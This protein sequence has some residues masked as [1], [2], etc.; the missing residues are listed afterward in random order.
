MSENFIVFENTFIKR[1]G[2]LKEATGLKFTFL[3]DITVL[4]NKNSEIVGFLD[5][6]Y[7]KEYDDLYIEMIE[8]I[9]KFRR[10]GYARATI[11]KIKELYP[12]A[13]IFGQ[14]D[15]TDTRYIWERLGAD[16]DSCEDVE[17]PYDSYEECS[18]PCDNPASLCFGFK[19]K[20]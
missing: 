18:Y 14:A 12:N 1:N 4:K 16:F 13:N 10:Q 9:P 5:Y 15:N 2:D 20:K 8:I 6:K 19:A 3:G 11:N 7:M 17:C